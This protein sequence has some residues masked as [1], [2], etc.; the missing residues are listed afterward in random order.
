MWCSAVSVPPP[1]LSLP[2]PSRGGL[3]KRDTWVGWSVCCV[4]GNFG[5]GGGGWRLM[6]VQSRAPAHPCASGFGLR[7]ASPTFRL[8]PWNLI[9]ECFL[10]ALAVASS[11]YCTKLNNHF[12]P[13]LS[14]NASMVPNFPMKARNSAG[15]TLEGMPPTKTVHG[16]GSGPGSGSG[17]RSGF[18]AG[19][20]SVVG[21]PASVSPQ[22]IV[23][24]RKG[25]MDVSFEHQ[26]PDG[27]SMPSTGKA[28][29]RIGPGRS[30]ESGLSRGDLL[31]SGEFERAAFFNDRVLML[32][33]RLTVRARPAVHTTNTL[34]LMHRLPSEGTFGTCSCAEQS[35]R[36][37]F[38]SSCPNRLVAVASGYEGDW[39]AVDGT[40][41]SDRD[42]TG[43]HAGKRQQHTTDW[44]AKGKE[45]EL[46]LCISSQ[47]QRLCHP[48]ELHQRAMQIRMVRSEYPGHPRTTICMKI[49]QRG[50]HG[51]LEWNTISHVDSQSYILRCFRAGGPGGCASHAIQE[52]G[53]RNFSCAVHSCTWLCLLRAYLQ[54]VGGWNGG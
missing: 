1:A 47:P 12:V 22:S 3:L 30:V 40:S 15:S 14:L 2:R 10:M 45:P 33:G 49:K 54:T 46:S 8:R 7:F 26:T 5:G 37:A 52:H 11:V 6:N 53:V 28:P 35:T 19:S 24:C 43:P 4:A 27:V 32:R 29:G 23:D 36:A 50:P 38:S 13:S 44:E 39:R 17:W 34:R 48:G 21:A 31:K 16:P 25:Q 20:A 41:E 51:A 18:G 9:L 42:A